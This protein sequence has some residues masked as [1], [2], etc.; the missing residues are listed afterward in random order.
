MP[1]DTGLENE[2]MKHTTVREADSH[3]HPPFSRGTMLE[4]RKHPRIA[5]NSGAYAVLI[6]PDGLPIGGKVID[7]SLGGIAFAYASPT[8]LEAKRLHLQLFNL[9]GPRSYTERIP[10]RVIRNLKIPD[11]SSG[12]LFSWQC[13]I[14]FEALT[15]DALEKMRN[16]VSALALPCPAV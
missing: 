9:N 3:T 10:C 13:G 16:F 7:I 8:E 5:I 15:H 2:S 4:Q 12:Y 14:Q 11:G 1:E 6:Q